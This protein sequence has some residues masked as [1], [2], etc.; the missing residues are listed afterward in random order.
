[1][2]ANQAK[3]MKGSFPFLKGEPDHAIPTAVSTQAP[4]PPP[5]R[6][7]GNIYAAVQ[8]QS[9]YNPGMVAPPDPT[10]GSPPGQGGMIGNNPNNQT[11]KGPPAK[12]VDKGTAPAMDPSRDGWG[13]VSG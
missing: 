12:Q 13:S 6:T 3:I 9:S 4:V 5:K 11:I 2:D 7:I 8:A 1:M 10:T